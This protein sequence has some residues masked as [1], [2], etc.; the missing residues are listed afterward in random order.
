MPSKSKSSGGTATATRAAARSKPVTLAPAP[1]DRSPEEA[2]ARGHAEA[3]VL[4]NPTSAA[5]GETQMMIMPDGAHA[6]V[7]TSLDD[8]A[9]PAPA[10][11]AQEEE[12]EEDVDQDVEAAVPLEEQEGIDDPVRM[13]LREIGKVSLL[14][15]D[16]EK[17]L[18]RQMEEGKHIERLRD[19]WA[20]SMGRAARV[21]DVAYMLLMELSDLEPVMRTIAGYA[22]VQS[23]DVADIIGDPAF[24]S[25]VDAEMDPEAAERVRQ[26]HGWPQDEDL[27]A[28][29]T[30]VQLSI[31]SHILN[32]DLVRG[33]QRNLP[34]GT[35]VLP[36]PDETPRAI[37]SDDALIGQFESLFTRIEL[38]GRKAERRLTE[39]N[40]RLVV[41]V[42]KKYIGR[43]MS[44]LDLIQDGNIGLIRAVEKFDYR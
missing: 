13:Y 16:D 9:E 2:I 29:K 27:R 4:P 41:S 38:E 7:P 12:E 34:E 18:A 23:P 19:S 5:P 42:A 43:G 28:E 37:A 15:A 39:A 17:R 3:E 24:R 26:E 36:P 31:V 44:L 25:V 6:T 22:N 14:S 33:V 30:I 32:P 40:L 1:E 21:S 10:T 8:I 35:P 11:L 20:Q